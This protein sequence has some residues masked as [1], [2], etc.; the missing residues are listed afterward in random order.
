MSIRVQAT[1]EGLLNQMTAS[2]YRIDDVVA[3][4]ALPNT[5]ALHRVV[6]LTNPLNSKTCIAQV[7]DVGPHNEHDPYTEQMQAYTPVLA[8]YGSDVRP[9]AEQ[10]ESIAGLRAANKAGIDLG[11]Y[12]WNALG[13]ADNTQ[14]D[15]YYISP[16]K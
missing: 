8:A 7:L 9:L 13:M 16:A 6:H 15:W 1:R 10:G 12:V 14:V 11:E 2:G 3:F 5:H 4:V